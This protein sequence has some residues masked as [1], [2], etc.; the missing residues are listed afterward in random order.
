MRVISCLCFCGLSIALSAQGG[1]QTF[2]SPDRAFQFKHSPGLI[3]CIPQ[4]D[5]QPRWWAPAGEC[6]SQATLCG[7]IGDSATTIVC[8][9]RPTHEHFA[10][11]FFVAE[12]QP[13]QCMEHWPNTTCRPLPIKRKDCLAGSSTWWPPKT[14]RN[15]TRGQNKRIDSVRAKLFHISDSWTSGGQSGDIYRVFHGKKCYELGIQEA[16][17]TST[18]FDPE[19]FDRIQKMEEEDDKK[20][21]PLLLQELHSFRFLT[22]DRP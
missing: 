19:E 10:S 20:Y 1:L 12:V 3:R 7:D 14:P 9:A 13:E 8:F 17:V 2:T 5:G 6:N 4:P 11:A 21:G 22:A 15:T 18:A 16:G